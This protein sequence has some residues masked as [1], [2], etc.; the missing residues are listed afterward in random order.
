MSSKMFFKY[1]TNLRFFCAFTECGHDLFCKKYEYC[2]SRPSLN[3]SIG[4]L[5]ELSKMFKK[6]YNSTLKLT[7]GV[8]VEGMYAKIRVGV[9]LKTQGNLYVDAGSGNNKFLFA[10]IVGN[11]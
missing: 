2:G 1:E 10:N 9:S 5:A 8:T 6:R 7:T 3:G 11:I 4:C